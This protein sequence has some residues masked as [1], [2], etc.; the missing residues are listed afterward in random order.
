M[1]FNV[2]FFL[3][4]PEDE[5]DMVSEGRKCFLDSVILDIICRIIEENKTCH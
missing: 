1:F 2:L 4:V 5:A 3:A